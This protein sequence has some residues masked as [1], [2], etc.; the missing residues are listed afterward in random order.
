MSEFTESAVREFR[1]NG[2][3]IRL[4]CTLCGFRSRA[5]RFEGIT[6]MGHEP[7]STVVRDCFNCLA[8][9][10]HEGEHRTEHFVD[11]ATDTEMLEQRYIEHSGKLKGEV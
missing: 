11:F 1:G 3:D 6:P 5:N 2:W 9:N 7:P 4:V 8:E 10:N